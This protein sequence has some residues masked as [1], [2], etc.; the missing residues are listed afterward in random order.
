[1]KR[2]SIYATWKFLFIIAFAIGMGACTE[3][4][5]IDH[6][7]KTTP[8]G[9]VR[10]TL[11]MNTGGY[12]QPVTR[13]NEN[14]I[15][16]TPWV[17]VFKG[18]GSTATFLEAKQAEYSS[19]VTSVTL[20][21]VNEAVRIMVLANVSTFFNGSAEVA[22]SETSLAALFT[23]GTTTYNTAVNSLLSVRL[24][25]TK[26]TTLPYGVSTDALPMS[27][28]LD[29]SSLNENTVI[30]STGTDGA[31][32]LLLR[33]AVAK[34]TVTNEASG[35]TLK[36]ATAV[37]APRNGTL[38]EPASMKDNTGNLT[39]YLTASN[40][41]LVTTSGTNTNENPI[42]VYESRT[43]EATAVIIKGAYDGTDYYYKLDFLDNTSGAAITV[44]RNKHYEFK[45]K[46]VNMPGYG[47]VAEANAAS[48]SNGKVTAVITVTDL[49][50]YDIIDNGE[51]YLGVSNSELLVYSD[52]A[53]TNYTA[54]TIETDAPATVT[55]RTISVSGTGLSLATPSQQIATGAPTDVKINLTT[56]FT[57]GTITLQL[58]NLKK[59][60]AVKREDMVESS[61]QAIPFSGSYAAGKIE[62]GDSWLSLSLDGSNNSG[63]SE[64]VRPDQAGTLYLMVVSNIG[65]PVNNRY[66]ELFLSR[67]EEEGRVKILV[68]QDFL[69]IIDLDNDPLDGKVFSYVGTFHKWNQTGERLIKTIQS[70]YQFNYMNLEGPWKASVLVGQ[71]WIILDT[72]ES[73][74][75]N[76][77]TS[78][79]ADMNDPINDALYQVTGDA[80]TVSGYCNG[81]D[82][83]YFRV[84]LT[85]TLSSA[86]EQRY[87]LISVIFTYNGETVQKLIYV[88][89][90]EAPDNI[91]D[92]CELKWSVYNLT[93][94]Q[95]R[96][97][98]PVMT[99]REGRFV[100]FPTKG[101]YYFIP[102]MFQ[103]YHPGL[104][105]SDAAVP[106]N[107]AANVWSDEREVCPEG[108]RQVHQ[109][110][111]NYIEMSAAT[112]KLE[113]LGLNEKN[114]F[115]YYADG[116]FDRQELEYD[117]RGYNNWHT[118]YGID[119]AYPGVLV[120]NPVTLA[121][122][123]LP[124]AG[125]MRSNETRPYETGQRPYYAINHMW[126]GSGRR[127]DARIGLSFIFRGNFSIAGSSSQGYSYSI[128][129]IKE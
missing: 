73:S 85:S 45:L 23:E 49:T 42:Y 19:G 22:L 74:D 106:T 43:N 82:E 62:T 4:T 123:F 54:L 20:S 12:E 89:Q 81:E 111:D 40:E 15:G 25:A 18:A 6:G 50:S 5:V 118:P 66:G 69:D 28:T 92:D 83:I 98:N 107:T 27:A 58:G 44:T 17:F 76:I 124:A 91:G 13:A 75:P 46:S 116:Y 59:T 102:N 93:D 65:H 53:L 125:S 109:E 21:P 100:D 30:N 26:Q 68:K 67:Q 55:T 2:K 39:D 48:A 57:T 52:E 16:N 33:R 127:F 31:G 128:R 80:I 7:G 126:G 9:K 96:Y 36:G 129:C 94:P 103:A 63:T 104:N 97:P 112:Q 121:S 60:I 8:D 78:A 35:F 11:T 47:T 86:D 51:Y 88:R 99:K 77:Y 70:P 115:G 32:G 34:V 79:P 3:E 122:L 72:E 61:K 24:A 95:K 110:G 71:E 90:G 64:V 14:L 41:V 101:G 38:F 84:G 105:N 117:N 119:V 120:A 29:L 10:L 87:G 1:M 37:N 114:S 108:Y 56:A 113:E